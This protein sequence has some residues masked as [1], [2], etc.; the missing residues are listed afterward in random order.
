MMQEATMVTATDPVAQGVVAVI[1]VGVF[2]LLTRE[3]AHRVVIAIGAVALLWAISYLT[4]L[5]LVTFEGMREALDL[6]VLVLL[7]AMMALVGVLKTTG[8]FEWAVALVLRSARGQPLVLLAYIIAFTAVTSA[9]LDNVTT[10]VF[11]APM[12][13]VM[14]R[15][16]GLS[17]AAFILPMVIGTLS[18]VIGLHTHYGPAV[19][20]GIVI[21]AVFSFIA[22]GGGLALGIAGAVRYSRDGRRMQAAQ[23]GLHLGKGVRLGAAPRL[24]G[25]TLNLT[26]RF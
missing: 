8:V 3:S 1:L 6:N 9:F 18:Y 12:A 20:G 7:A 26:Y 5:R 2:A 24:G 13:L 10:V 19:S 17:P 25:G 11:L 14:A 4:P 21:F 22:Q 16:L 15:Q 23:A